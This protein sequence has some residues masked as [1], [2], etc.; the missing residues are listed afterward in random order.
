MVLFLSGESSASA[1]NR[2]FPSERCSVFKRILLLQLQQFQCR[3]Q[4]IATFYGIVPKTTEYLLHLDLS[5]RAQIK[6]MRVK[7]GD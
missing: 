1:V 2:P 3:W 7:R 6:A 4:I 5:G